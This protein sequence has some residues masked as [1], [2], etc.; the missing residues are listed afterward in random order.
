MFGL[1]NKNKKTAILIIP[2]KQYD[3]SEVHTLNKIFKHHQIK[4]IHAST[5]T[6]GPITG[7]NHGTLKA[8][9]KISDIYLDECDA[10]VLV[11]GVGARE[12]YN[13]MNL[14]RILRTANQMKK[15][16]GAIDYAPIILAHA[17]I[18]NDKRVAV[19]ETEET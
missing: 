6:V 18:L 13:D 5:F 9:I 2:S 7:M 19:I 8:E 11:G 1:G 16:I 3:E 12:Q 10:L 17:E 15:V 4:C 14:H